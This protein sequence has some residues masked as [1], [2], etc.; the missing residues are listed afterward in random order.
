[1]MPT[2]V[3]E[4][5]PGLV[6]GESRY[7]R[8]VGGLDESFMDCVFE[9]PVWSVGELL[10]AQVAYGLEVWQY[11]EFKRLLDHRG[12]GDRSVVLSLVVFSGAG[13]WWWC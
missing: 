8:I 2:K 12:Q 9:R 7:W 1:M 3:H 6:L 4:Q 13:Q 5:D 11:K 10:R